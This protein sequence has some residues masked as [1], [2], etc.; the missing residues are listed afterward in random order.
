MHYVFICLDDGDQ[1]SAR[2]KYLM[3]HLRYIETKL[4]KVVLAGPCSPLE[5]GDRRE[6]QGSIMIY[7]ANTELEARAM[8][9]GDP[10]AKNGVWSSVKVLPFSAVAGSLI[11][12]KTWQ[13]DGNDIKRIEL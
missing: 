8:F 10:Y 1:S 6:Y 12:G 4:D 13:I 9:E 5:K 2:Q 3:A 7:D 11:G